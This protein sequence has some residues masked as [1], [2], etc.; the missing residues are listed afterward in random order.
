MHG[1]A[2]WHMVGSAATMLI[3]G[4]L[5]EWNRRAGVRIARNEGAAQAYRQSL[6]SLKWAQPY[7]D[8]FSWILLLVGVASIIA[9]GWLN[10]DRGLFL[11]VGVYGL[12]MG[13]LVRWATR[14]AIHKTERRL[15]T[16][17]GEEVG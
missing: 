14:S 11:V 15:A 13:P 9:A 2:S 12:T 1:H 7:V 4:F 16:L 6:H 10:V 5:V 3:L 8:V 17:S